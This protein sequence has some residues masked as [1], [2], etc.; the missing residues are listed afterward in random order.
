MSSR[1]YYDFNRDSILLLICNLFLSMVLLGIGNP[2]IVKALNTSNNEPG[3]N[4]DFGGL[5]AESTDIAEANKTDLMRDVT[6]DNTSFGGLSA[7]STDTAEA[8]KTDLRNGTSN[9]SGTDFGGL[10]AR[11]VDIAK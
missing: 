3:H 9:N 1:L 5:S 2:T 8:N 11:S 6:S 7:E 4:T 10:S